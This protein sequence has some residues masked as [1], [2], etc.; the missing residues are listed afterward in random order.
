MSAGMRYMWSPTISLS[1]FPRSKV[2]DSTSDLLFFKKDTKK[3]L[4]LLIHCHP[5]I[6]YDDIC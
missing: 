3:N 2:N 6:R 5:P 4:R 1:F